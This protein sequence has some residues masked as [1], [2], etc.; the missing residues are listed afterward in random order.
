[1]HNFFS[2]LL[3]MYDF[4]IAQYEN[5]L[6]LFSSLFSSHLDIFSSNMFS[7]APINSRLNVVV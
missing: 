7:D 3:Y 1:M 4:Q 2:N 5:F 6:L